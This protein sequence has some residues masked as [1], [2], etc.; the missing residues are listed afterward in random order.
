METQIESLLGPIAEML[1]GKFGSFAQ[2]ISAVAVGVGTFR[3]FF[4]PLMEA[5][6]KIILATPSKSDDEALD[7]VKKS[8][9]YRA[10][11]FL[12]DFLLSIK[13][14]VVEKVVKR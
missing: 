12:T 2:I 13:V 10:F 11:I 8:L 3:L 7:V 9:L 6:E 5:A 1:I 14:P 4:K